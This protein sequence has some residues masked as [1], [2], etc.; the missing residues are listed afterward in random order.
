MGLATGV[1]RPPSSGTAPPVGGS[2]SASTSSSS[3]RASRPAATPAEDNEKICVF[4][5]LLDFRL[6][7]E[8][9]QQ[10]RQGGGVARRADRAEEEEAARG[11]V[12]STQR[13]R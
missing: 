3:A 1:G 13:D 10:Q 7:G 2:R 9:A 5:A 4:D 11:G 6:T 12:F 8:L